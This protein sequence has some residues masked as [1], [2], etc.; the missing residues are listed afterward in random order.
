MEEKNELTKVHDKYFR[1]TFGR[2]RNTIDLLENLLSPED[3]ERI[4][5]DT[6][7]TMEETYVDR[8]FDEHRTDVIFKANLKEDDQQAYIC[9]LFEHKSS[10]ERLTVLQVLNYM[11]RIWTK[12]QKESRELPIVIPIVFYHGSRPWT[13]PIKLS[14]LFNLNEEA[15]N[16][17]YFPEFEPILV[18]MEELEKR[19]ETFDILTVRLYLRAINIYRAAKKYERTGNSD[20]FW[21]KFN[22]YIDTLKEYYDTLSEEEQKG[23]LLADEIL[24]LSWKYVMYCTPLNFVEEANDVLNEKIPEGSENFMYVKDSV[25]TK[26]KEEGE[27]KGMEKARKSM[28]ETV[29][30]L[31]AEE[32]GENLSDVLTRRLNECSYEKLNEIVLNSRGISDEDDVLKLLE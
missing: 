5:L 25:Y 9:C 7:N 13:Q 23:V 2:N 4:D 28:L 18:Q 10:Q 22:D 15:A 29:E 6:L 24:S 27:Q 12:K 19:I 16:L 8:D 20:L 1:K 31:L 30:K 21:A 17:T 14:E 26:G 3:L 32:L 11:V